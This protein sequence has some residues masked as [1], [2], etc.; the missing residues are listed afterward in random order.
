[1]L[2]DLPAVVGHNRIS[3]VGFQGLQVLEAFALEEFITHRQGLI[4]HQHIR[5][6]VGLYRECQLQCHAA[7]WSYRLVHKIADIGEAEDRI[8]A[9]VGLLLAQAQQC[10]I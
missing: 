9:G 10:R 2:K 4:H 7:G 3:A 5:L 8:E 6:D 1:M